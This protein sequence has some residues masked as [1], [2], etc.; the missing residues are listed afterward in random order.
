MPH[1][2]M[3]YSGNAGEWGDQDIIT[4]AVHDALCSLE[5]LPTETIKT[6]AVQHNHFY[7]GGD[8]EGRKGF[9][10]VLIRTRPGREDHVL[11]EMSETARAAVLAHVAPVSGKT[12]SVS[13]EVQMMDPVAVLHAKI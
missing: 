3:E 11:L 8:V 6:R 12:L 2:I 1:V 10:T 5:H 13:I 9:V 7:I 4:K